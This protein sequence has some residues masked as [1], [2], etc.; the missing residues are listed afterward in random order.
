[1][2]LLLLFYFRNPAV[3]SNFTSSR[4][5]MI[6][7]VHLLYTNFVNFS[8]FMYC[9]LQHHL[10]LMGGNLLLGGKQCWACASGQTKR[11]ILS[12][13]TCTNRESKEKI[14]LMQ[15]NHLEHVDLLNYYYFGCTKDSDCPS[16]PDC[17]WQLKAWGP[18]GT[19]LCNSINFLS[20]SC[21]C[22]LLECWHRQSTLWWT[23]VLFHN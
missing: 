1:M 22:T 2:F 4:L 10:L 11:T 21:I 5:I 14:L 9:F 7:S 8:P 17:G 20:W 19:Q 23:Y 18:L 12:H 13:S 16:P 6:I 3:A 15:M